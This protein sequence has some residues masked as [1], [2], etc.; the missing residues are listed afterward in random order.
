VDPANFQLD[1][2]V[3]FVLGGEHSY[4]NCQPA[5]GQN[6]RNSMGVACNQAKAFAVS[7]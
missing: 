2:I 5:H 4:A 6:C 1:H 7:R 3:P